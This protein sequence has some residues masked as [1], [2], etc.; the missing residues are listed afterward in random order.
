MVVS[1]NEELAKVKKEAEALEAAVQQN[2][3]SDGGDTGVKLTELYDKLH[4]LNSDAAKAQASKIL[5]GS[6]PTE[7]PPPLLQLIEVSFCYPKMP[8]FRLSNVDVDPAEG[9]VRRSQ[10]L[11]IGRYSQH[12]VDQLKMVETPVQYLLRRHPDQEGY[13]KQEA[14][15]AKLGKFGLS[16]HNHCEKG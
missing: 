10:K 13:S 16:I 7:I 1:A 2:S 3:F 11:R 9:G 6:D 5:A 14:V 15:C 8:D 4:E 12:F